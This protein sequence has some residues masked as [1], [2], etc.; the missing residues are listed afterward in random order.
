MCLNTICVPCLQRSE[1]RIK[2]PDGLSCHGTA[3]NWTW[4]S[5]RTDSVFK[6][7][8][9]LQAHYLVF[10]L[11]TQ[12]K[13]DKKWSWAWW[14]TSVISVSTQKAEA[15]GSPTILEKLS[16]MNVL[17]LCVA[18]ITATAS[19]LQSRWFT[20]EQHPWS[21]QQRWEKRAMHL[22]GKGWGTWRV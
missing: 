18:E 20:I 22:K 8:S 14:L 1:E 4:S 2:C 6:A 12:I 9:S 16:L 13:I 5:R 21:W 10:Y 3:G 17:L 19:F 15:G 11:L 7:E